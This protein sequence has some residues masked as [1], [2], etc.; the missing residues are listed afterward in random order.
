MQW[1]EKLEECGSARENLDRWDVGVYGGQASLA[2][3]VKDHQDAQTIIDRPPA[4]RRWWCPTTGAVGQSS[5]SLG[6]MRCGLADGQR[7]SVF[8]V[9]RFK[10]AVTR[11]LKGWAHDVAEE[12]EV[13]GQ[14]AADAAGGDP[15]GRAGVPNRAL[16][17]QA[18]W[19]RVV[20]LLVLTSW[21]RGKCIFGTAGLLWPCPIRC[22]SRGCC[23]SGGCPCLPFGVCHG[24]GSG[25]GQW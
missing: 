18:A 21:P 2:V 10:A 8:T 24:D 20:D 25:P 12:R 5:C 23:A 1:L 3:D 13:L 4:R 9:S 19:Q 17:E 7:Y 6:S 16:E 15:A 14:R 22:G 11:Q